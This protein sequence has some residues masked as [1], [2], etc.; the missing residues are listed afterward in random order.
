MRVVLPT[1]ALRAARIR[2]LARAAS[3]SSELPRQ[4]PATSFDQDRDGGSADLSDRLLHRLVDA[5]SPPSSDGEALAA[6]LLA[7]TRLGPTL[8]ESSQ[9]TLNRL[10]QRAA[11]A[12]CGMGPVLPGPTDGTEHGVAELRLRGAMLAAHG[13]AMGQKSF[14]SEAGTLHAQNT[15]GAVRRLRTAGESGCEATFLAAGSALSK[16]MLWLGLTGEHSATLY[17]RRRG[18]WLTGVMRGR[19]T[20]RDTEVVDTWAWSIVDAVSAA[21]QACDDDAVAR[22]VALL[23]GTARDGKGGDWSAVSAEVQCHSSPALAVAALDL[24]AAQAG[25]SW[26]GAGDTA[27]LLADASPGE[28]ALALSHVWLAAYTR[29]VRGGIPAGDWRVP[30]SSISQ[31][32]DVLEH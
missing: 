17:T 23:G 14:D 32:L 10:S 15:L 11:Q 8:Q 16:H 12:V 4:L 29:A 22:L 28:R 30:A 20:T 3:T 9:G 2:A 19:P 18:M 5:L 26:S 7:A 1:A 13:V 25:A 27:R 24:A 21:A 31:A 6:P